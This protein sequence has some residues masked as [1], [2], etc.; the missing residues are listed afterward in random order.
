MQ[1]YASTVRDFLKFTRPK[2]GLKGPIRVKLINKSIKH[3]DQT[4]FGYFDAQSKKIV[5]SVKDRHPTDV[6]RTLCH[7]LV[8]LAQ[9]Q[10]R[11]LTREDGETGSDI[12]N[13]ANAVAGIIMRLWNQ[14]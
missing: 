2:L 12:E 8:H 11:P 5:I 10:A 4:T 9:S 7:E 13:Q 1:H 6:L 14:R 3:G